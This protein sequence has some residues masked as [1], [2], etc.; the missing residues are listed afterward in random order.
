MG[1]IAIQI[2][3]NSAGQSFFHASQ[4]RRCNF[5]IHENNDIFLFDRLFKNSKNAIQLF[6][7]FNFTEK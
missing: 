2:L 1:K 3:Y 7:Q 4:C 5:I 6:N